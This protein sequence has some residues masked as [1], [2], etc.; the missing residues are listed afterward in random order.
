[1]V[2]LALYAPALQKVF[3]FCGVGSNVSYYV[4]A[5]C[6]SLPKTPVSDFPVRACTCARSVYPPVPCVLGFQCGA[7]SNPGSTS[8]HRRTRVPLPPPT[9]GGSTLTKTES[10]LPTQEVSLVGAPPPQVCLLC[11]GLRPPRHRMRSSVPPARSSPQRV[12]DGPQF[13]P[14]V[15]A[16]KSDTVNPCTVG[17]ART[18]TLR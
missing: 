17:G 12:Q 3:S 10:S 2:D 14:G 15:H 9:G 1:M 7:P 5:I 13:R 8:V 6:A 4:I 16:R 18:L 11:P